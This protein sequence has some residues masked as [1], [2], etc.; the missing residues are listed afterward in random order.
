MII[1]LFILIICLILFHFV[2]WF[3]LFEL[4]KRIDKRLDYI[5]RFITNSVE[6]LKVLS[7]DV[8]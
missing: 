3:F 7:K 1:Y 6:L 4:A 8:D 5:S 2:S